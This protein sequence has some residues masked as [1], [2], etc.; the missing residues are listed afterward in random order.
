MKNS[1]DICRPEKLHSK[2]L[3][4]TWLESLS[5]NLDRSVGKTIRRKVMQGSEK[6]AAD[7]PLEERARWFKG[8]ME[9]LDTLVDEKE[10]RT[11]MMCSCPDRFPKKRIKFLRK[12]YLELGSIDALFPIMNEDTSW[13]GLSYYEYPVRKGNVI[14]VTKIPYNPKGVKAARNAEEKRLS[15]CHCPIM[16]SLLKAG[17]KVSPTFCYCGAGWYKQLWEG[18]LE[19]PIEKIE[20]LKSVCGGDDSCEYAIHLPIDKD[21]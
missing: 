11:I 9:R 15:Y 8:A 21:I 6:L 3:L 13:K 4:L 5:E 20:M 12:K 7:S 19:E 18:I 1:T 16:K 2:V 17:E 10:R 14:Y